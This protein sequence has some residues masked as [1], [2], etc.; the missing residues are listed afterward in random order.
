MV[1]VWYIMGKTE[2]KIK[3]KAIQLLATQSENL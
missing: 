3:T 1:E 2:L